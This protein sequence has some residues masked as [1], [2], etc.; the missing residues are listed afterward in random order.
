LAIASRTS[1][2]AAAKNREINAGL[3]VANAELR[4]AL[5]REL[6]DR[7][8][9]TLTSI[10]MDL[11][12]FK[13]EQAGQAT[14]LTKVDEV[15]GSMRDVLSSLRDLLHDLRGESVGVAGDIREGLSTLLSGFERR[16]GIMS[17]LV[18]HPAWPERTRP[19]AGLN[20][21][22]I[23]EEAL[24]NAARHSGAKQVRL[25]LRPVAGE[26]L[27]MTITDYGRGFDDDTVV[28][29]MG[30]VGMRERAVLIGARLW[31]DSFAGYGTSVHVIMPRSALT[32][33][34]G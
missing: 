17:T 27:C 30:T 4:T 18:V 33:G 29:G 24:V 3:H 13:R 5:A 2:P 14:V 8:A 1:V 19:A 15:Q 7:V 6:H 21:Y 25:T 32:P 12:V 20:L 16:T 31:I 26:E 22:R 9:Q 23:A 11:E 34:R 28:P 10:L